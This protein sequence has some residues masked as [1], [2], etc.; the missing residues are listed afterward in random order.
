MN[1]LTRLL[2]PILG[3][4]VLPI[5][6]IGQVIVFAPTLAARTGDVLTLPIRLVSN[7]SI[8][9]LQFTLKWNASVLKYVDL[10][11]LGLAGQSL[12]GNFGRTDTTNG[13]IRFLWAHPQTRNLQVLDTL[14]LFLLK[15]RVIGAGGT[16][17]LIAIAD[18][19]TKA[20]SISGV[21]GLQKPIQKRNGVV[22]V[23]TTGVSEADVGQ[24]NVFLYP[25]E[26]N[27]V[28]DFFHI[29]F[30]LYQTS[31]I[32]CYLMDIRG[33]IVPAFRGLYP[34]GTHRIQIPIPHLSTGFYRLVLNANG[35]LQQRALVITH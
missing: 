11:S 2:M 22:N 1:F 25:S 33:Q 5:A 3:G 9:G 4:I 35:Q 27:P 7:D 21:N 6:V 20:I 34:T 24:K 23:L 17:S 13:T 15:L 10:T 18:T 16:S 30:D 26:P 19:P 28:T 31:E 32:T 14:T 12:D 29:K 8:N